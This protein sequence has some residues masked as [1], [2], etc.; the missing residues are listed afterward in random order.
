MLVASAGARLPLHNA[1]K[2]IYRLSADNPLTANEMS[3]TATPIP[4]E[5]AQQLLAYEET[6][7]QPAEGK[8]SAA[9]RVCEKLRGPLGKVLGVGGFRSLLSRAL[10]LTCE[11]V[12]WLCAL[13]VKADGT[14][15]GLDELEAKLDPRAIT[16]G[17]AVLVGQ[18]LGLLIIFIGPALTLGLL[19][20][21]WPKWTIEI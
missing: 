7:G 14:L 16:E 2:A 6:S 15:E 19:H 11:E 9:F 5:F 13:Q 18:L 17:E 21:I 20:N 12:P 1:L 10:A 8:D 3:K 4:K